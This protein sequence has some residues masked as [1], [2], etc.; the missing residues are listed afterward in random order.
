MGERRL[1]CCSVQSPAEGYLPLPRVAAALARDQADRVRAS[2]ERRTGEHTQCRTLLPSIT[3]FFLDQ[4]AETF[5]VSVWFVQQVNGGVQ[6]EVGP[7]Q[8]NELLD[9]VRKGNVRPETKLR[10]GDSAWFPASDVGGLF[11]AASKLPLKFFCPSCGVEVSRPPVTCKQCLHDIQKG[12]ARVVSP[13]QPGELP[14]AVAQARQH[15]DHEARQSMQNWLR[16][17]FPRRSG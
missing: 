5:I 13:E 16:K 7:L 4:R 11:E 1:D 3:S 8:P 9:L 12:E 6:T 15:A 10:K 14:K 2:L 17:R